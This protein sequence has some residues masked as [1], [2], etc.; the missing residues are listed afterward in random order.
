LYKS[1]SLRL[2]TA[3]IYRIYIQNIGVIPINNP[4]LAYILATPLWSDIACQFL[5]IPR[6]WIDAKRL[7]SLT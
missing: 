2:P 5:G 4:V 1:P 3:S 7:D 6:L